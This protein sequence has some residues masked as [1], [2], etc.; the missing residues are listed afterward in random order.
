MEEKH[1]NVCVVNY[2]FFFLSSIVLNL[3]VSSHPADLVFFCHDEMAELV[4]LGTFEGLKSVAR[5]ITLT[6]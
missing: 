1:P 5:R 4:S 6:A 3:I 2:D